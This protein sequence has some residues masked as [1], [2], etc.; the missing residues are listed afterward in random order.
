PL[1]LFDLV[2]PAHNEERTLPR[3]MESISALDYPP[4]RLRVHIVADNCTDRTAEVARRAGAIVYERRDAERIGKGFAISLGLSAALQLAGQAHDG[5]VFIDADSDLTPQFL[6]VL[7]AYL[8]AGAQ[9]IQAYYSVRN[10]GDSSVAMLRYVALCL[11]HYLRPLGRSRLGLSAGLRGNGMCFR[12][13]VA[14]LGWSAHGL[15]E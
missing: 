8:D 6:R 3:L 2:I 14:E 15:T 10:A 13:Q 4:E 12:R 1:P 5:V 7:A 9:A 11:Y